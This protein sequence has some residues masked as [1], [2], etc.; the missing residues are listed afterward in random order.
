MKAHTSKGEKFSL[1][2][3][4]MVSRPPLKPALEQI[5][6]VRCPVCGHEV[7]V[8]ITKTR[9]PFVNCGFCSARIFY[10]GRESMRLLLGQME[11]VTGNDV[12]KLEKGEER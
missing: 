3:N 5:G 12:L 6:T 11:P 7:A 2:K 8:H 4:S 9:R 1:T 10:N